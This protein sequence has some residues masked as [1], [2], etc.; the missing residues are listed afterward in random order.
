MPL[1]KAVKSPGDDQKDDDWPK[2][3]G[4]SEKQIK[5]SFSIKSHGKKSESK[6][7]TKKA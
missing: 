5:K 2:I 3:V 1:T 4:S 6:H 7:Q